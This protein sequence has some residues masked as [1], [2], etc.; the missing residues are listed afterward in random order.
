MSMLRSVRGKDGPE[1]GSARFE[2]CN[3]RRIGRSPMMGR[4]NHFW[5]SLANHPGIDWFGR[6]LGVYPVRIR[7]KARQNEER[8]LKLGLDDE[9]LA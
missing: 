9:P 7:R 4:G 6:A 5:R 1:N 3:R 2:G 8:R